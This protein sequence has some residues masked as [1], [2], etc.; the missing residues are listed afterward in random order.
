[1]PQLPHIEEDGMEPCLSQRREAH[2]L[3]T[4]VHSAIVNDH[5]AVVLNWDW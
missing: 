4:L 3:M 1:M 2:L 5:A